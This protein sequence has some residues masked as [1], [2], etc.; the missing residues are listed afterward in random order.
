MSAEIWVVDDDP[1]LRWVLER[2]LLAA[3][4]VV[5]VFAD[6]DTALLALD[7]G[8]PAALVTDLRMPGP[9]GLSLLDASRSSGRSWPTIVITAHSD[10]NSAISAYRAG[11]F[12]YLPKPFDLDELVALVHKALECAGGSGQAPSEPVPTPAQA[13]LGEAPAMQAVYRMIGRL[14]RSEMA[15]LITGETGTGKELIAKALHRHSPR[16]DR[17]LVAL[18]TAAIP[19]DLLESELFGHERGAFT[20]ADQARV[21]RFEQA[22]GGSLFL[23]EIGDMPLALQTRLLRVLA[24]GEFY[25]LGGHAPLRAD[26]R[27]LAATHRDLDAEV[28][29]GRF[30]EDLYHR[31]NVIRLQ[32]PALRERRE[33][34]PSLAAHFLVQAALELRAPAK[35]L[36]EPARA[37]L[38]AHDWPGNVRELENTCRWLS[39]MAPGR[40]ITVEDL[41]PL[42][43]RRAPEASRSWEQGAAEWI[44]RLLAEQRPGIWQ[45]ASAA[46]EQLMIERALIACDG[47]RQRAAAA[48]GIGRNTLSRK[49]R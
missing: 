15:V 43:G 30:R 17:P 48:L 20:G 31:L 49:L 44:D 38:L 10:L 7:K 33:D 24:E 28:R 2:A 12:E 40:E 19:A 47:E 42:A 1:A 27:I 22:R 18:N 3:G 6:A 9:G 23:D 11:A 41:P 14:S 45:Q 8:R 21:G 35:A 5:R 46:L 32:V 29:A 39:V 34:I 26:V 36:T 25:R 13:L 37:A 16:A 4:F